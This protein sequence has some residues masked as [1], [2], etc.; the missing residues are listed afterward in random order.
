MCISLSQLVRNIG[1]SVYA[2]IAVYAGIIVYAGMAA[3]ACLRRFNAITSIGVCNNLDY[4]STRLCQ[5]CLL[6]NSLI[7]VSLI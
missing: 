7:D 1:I 4:Y 3:F 6:V 5:L 2:A